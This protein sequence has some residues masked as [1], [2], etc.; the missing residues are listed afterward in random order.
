MAGYNQ[1][2]FVDDLLDTNEFSPPSFTV[3]LY[4]E[5]WNLNGGSKFLYNN[6]VAVSISTF[7]R[8]ESDCLHRLVFTGRYPSAKNTQ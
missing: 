8:P 5:H 4:P 7:L 1:T 2:R 6:Q 3:N